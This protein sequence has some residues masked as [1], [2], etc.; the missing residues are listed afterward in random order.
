MCKIFIPF[1]LFISC[2]SNENQSDNTNCRNPQIQNTTIF[3]KEIHIPVDSLQYSH[4]C[5]ASYYNDSL[6]LYFGLDNSRNAIDI[7]DL[8]QQKYVRS[9]QI[10]VGKNLKLTD[11]YVHN[12]DSIFLFDKNQYKLLLVDWHGHV[13]FEK[14]L[15]DPFIR[16]LHESGKIGS[17]ESGGSARIV[18]DAQ[19]KHLFFPIRP[20][21]TEE[22][23][24]YLDYPFLL[25]YN[26][27][28]F[29]A[30]KVLGRYPP[31]FI[32]G[33]LTPL[34]SWI[35]IVRI[36]DENILLSFPSSTY[37]VNLKWRENEISELLCKK[38]NFIDVGKVKFKGDH[39]N[40]SDRIRYRTENGY[41]SEPVYSSSQKMY[42]LPVAHNQQLLDANGIINYRTGHPW[43]LIIMNERFEARKEIVFPAK[44]YCYYHM[45]PCREGVLILKENPASLTNNED[46]LD[47]V[48]VSN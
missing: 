11:F 20:I 2:V 35:K 34:V 37:L 7:Y 45:V 27:A 12:T 31:D 15:D 9:I 30:T 18:Y 28:E 14:R 13:K 17:L 19:S 8:D 40:Y 3:V 39:Q 46:T 6:N 32:P 22:A 33:N 1:L 41:F 21:V 5:N 16:E 29:K 24:D 25:A 47:G 36:K 48:I 23:N 42:Y 4:L 38:S 44:E 10:P 43:S 26:V